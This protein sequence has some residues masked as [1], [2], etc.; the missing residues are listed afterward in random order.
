MRLEKTLDE[1]IEQTLKITDQQ[2]EEKL[3]QFQGNRDL[4]DCTEL[5]KLFNDDDDEREAKD[6][7]IDF[8]IL[9]TTFKLIGGTTL[10]ASFVLMNF[11]NQLV[12]TFSGFYEK[13]YF[14]MDE[15]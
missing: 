9:K 14:T 3:I 15:A 7:K 8:D 4:E 13:D 6:A 2:V 11:L 5:G 12:S 10:I 1:Q